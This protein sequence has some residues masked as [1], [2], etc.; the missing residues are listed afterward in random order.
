MTSKGQGAAGVRVALVVLFIGMGQAS[1]E[2]LRSLGMDALTSMVVWAI[3]VV[4]AAAVTLVLW[5]A[6]DRAF[7]LRNWL[8]VAI[9]IPVYLGGAFGLATATAS[10]VASIVSGVGLGVAAVAVAGVVRSRRRVSAGQ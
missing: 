4:T 9:S 3:P 8:P 6:S 2:W 1:F 5:V 10:L 7:T